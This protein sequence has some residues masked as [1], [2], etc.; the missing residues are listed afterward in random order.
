MLLRCEAFSSSSF[1]PDNNRVSQN[2]ATR[3]LQQCARAGFEAV[4]LKPF[5]VWRSHIYIYMLCTVCPFLCMLD[6]VWSTHSLLSLAGDVVHHF[7]PLAACGTAAWV[8]CVL[9][10]GCI[11]LFAAL[12]FLP[13]QCCVAFFWDAH[14]KPG[15]SMG[16]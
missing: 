11:F 4:F 10:G 6:K 5:F 7:V 1:T 8:V 3:C 14:H 12:L 13:L 2:S 15:G 9:D 16:P